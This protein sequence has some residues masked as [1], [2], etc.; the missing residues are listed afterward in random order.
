MDI[1]LGSFDAEYFIDNP[2]ED[3]ICGIC[4]TVM[5]RPHCCK[6]GHSFCYNC[7]ANWLNRNRKTCPCDREKLTFETLTFN[8]PLH[9]LILKMKTRCINYQ[10]EEV[11]SEDR[12]KKRA[13]RDLTDS[14]SDWISKNGCSWVGCLS[15]R[16]AHQTNDCEFAKVKC[17]FEGCDALIRRN[18][19]DEHKSNCEH[20]L[21]ACQNCGINAKF[22]CQQLHLT[23]CDRVKVDCTFNCGAVLERR[24][25]EAHEEDCPLVEVPCYYV[26]LGCTAKMCRRDLPT[27]MTAT[28]CAHNVI[29]AGV[30][31][32]LRGRVT[33]LE[34]ENSRL[35]NR[36]SKV[37]RDY[38]TLEEKVAAPSQ[39]RVRLNWKVDNFYF[40]CLN[41]TDFISNKAVLCFH[42][43]GGVYH[44][45][46]QLQITDGNVG[47][48]IVDAN[49][50]ESLY[51]ITIDNSIIT[52]SH[53]T[54]ST[55]DVSQILNDCEI[56]DAEGGKGSSNFISLD[57]CKR[58]FCFPDGSIKVVAVI[59]ATS[60]GIVTV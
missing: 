39:A 20:R 1:E 45:K 24:D 54:S 26:H 27:H 55:L 47:I 57:E 60:V 58:D 28:A 4:S 18:F 52:L 17:G 25:I 15:E 46:L 35:R 3:F 8:R 23:T 11:G 40:L 6:S 42:G 41:K 9:N 29:I 50:S 53:P 13:K 10:C 37:E 38:I 7:I 51:P 19:V 31:N 34:Y 14:D 36:V 48:F 56:E 16:E 43:G 12:D 32:S 59:C 30:T 2:E 44:F 21:V 22:N 5:D 49:H 33:Q